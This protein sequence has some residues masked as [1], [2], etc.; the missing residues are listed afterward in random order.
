VRK[1]CTKP[2]S[3]RAT[4]SESASATGFAASGGPSTPSHE[5][6]DAPAG[7]PTNAMPVASSGERHLL[8]SGWLLESFDLGYRVG[9]SASIGELHVVLTESGDRNFPVGRFNLPDDVLRFLLTGE[10][11]Q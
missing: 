5:T 11:T 9:R 1:P 2:A 7:E 3:A 6:L 4:D 10:V 8:S